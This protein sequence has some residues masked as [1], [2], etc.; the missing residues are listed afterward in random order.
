M[1][2]GAGHMMDMNNRMK[3]NRDH[4]KSKRTKKESGFIDEKYKEPL[5]FK[6]INESKVLEVR[7]SI[8]SKN[9]KNKRKEQI[10]ALGIVF[11]LILSFVYLLGQIN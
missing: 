2:L 5:N 11:I 7:N 9:L 10:I 4:S 3:Q 6:H 8:A 1:G